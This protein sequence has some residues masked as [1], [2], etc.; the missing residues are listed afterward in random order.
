MVTQAIAIAE[1]VTQMQADPEYAKL[2]RMTI[3]E[4]VS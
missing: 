3:H 1:K 2:F 4:L